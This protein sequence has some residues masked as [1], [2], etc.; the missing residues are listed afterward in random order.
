MSGRWIRALVGVGLLAFGALSGAS[1]TVGSDAGSKSACNSIKLGETRVFYKQNMRCSKAK[2][3]ARRLYKTDG[4]DEPKN[5]T[6]ESG[7]NFNEGGGCSHDFKN[8][9]FGWHPLD[10]RRP[11]AGEQLAHHSAPVVYRPRPGCDPVV[12][13]VYRGPQPPGSRSLSCKG[14]GAGS[15]F[16]SPCGPAGPRFQDRRSFETT[17]LMRAP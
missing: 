7:S 8:K 6:C 17:C 12:F 14:D 10:K 5:F 15:R 2:H 1:S 4:R 9:F 13:A 3:H 16:G 11:K